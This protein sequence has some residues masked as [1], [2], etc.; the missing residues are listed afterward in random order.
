MNQL[1]S[2]KCADRVK[3]ATELAVQVLQ[4]YGEPTM[5]LKDLRA[6]LDQE[7]EGISL[8]ELILI[9]RDSER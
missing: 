8:S 9:E 7:L 3:N 4:R 5:S 1:D 2:K 6:T